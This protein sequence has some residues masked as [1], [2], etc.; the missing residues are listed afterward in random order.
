[1]G[2]KHKHLYE[3]IHNIDNLRLAYK[4]ASRGGNRFTEGNLRFQENLEA[5]LYHIQQRLIDETYAHG[6][7]SQFEVYEPKKRTIN[8]LPFADRVVQHA[9]NNIIEPIF[10]NVFYSCTYACRKNKGTHAGVRV[11]QS[12]MRH[13][14]VDGEVFF[15]K[16]DFSK[17]YASIDRSVLFREIERKISDKKVI[18]LLEQFGDRHGV[19]IPI[20]NLLSQLCANIYGH[21]F[22]RHIKEELGIKHYFR[23]MDDTVILSND[24]EHLKE[25]QHYLESFAKTHMKLKFSQWMI[26]SVHKQVNFLG[27]RI[28]PSYKLIRKDSVT[29]AKR[30][31]KR[32]VANGDSES[33]RA[34]LASW[35][36]HVKTADSHNLKSTIR[37]MYEQCAA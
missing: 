16:M 4:K 35:Y 12:T 37:G 36:G 17:Y 26:S 19:G 34:F 31:V 23:Y 15:L 33:L 14:E 7:Y 11:V 5:N 22:D 28:T 32:Y 30:K 9:I 20:G 8:A 18:A 6:A 24:K 2:T 10:D 13:I 21:I 29:R 3:Q 1:M 27:Y 25:L